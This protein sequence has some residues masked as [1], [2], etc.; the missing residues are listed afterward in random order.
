MNINPKTD[1]I[2]DVFSIYLLLSCLQLKDEENQRKNELYRERICV[3]V[4]GREKSVRP[5][6][7]S[8]ISGSGKRQRSARETHAAPQH[9]VLCRKW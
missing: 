6:S 2:I 3:R 8:T 5:Q 9:P 7:S 4:Q 1:S